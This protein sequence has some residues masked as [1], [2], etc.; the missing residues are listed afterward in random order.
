[1]TAPR[2]LVVDDEPDVEAL[3]TQ[4]FRRKVRSGEI[5]FVFAQDGVQALEVL[6]QTPDFAAETMRT[7]LDGE[8]AGAY[9]YYEVLFGGHNPYMEAIE[10]NLDYLR[11]VLQKKRWSMLRRVPPC[12][13]W[14]KNALQNMRSLVIEYLK[15]A[16]VAA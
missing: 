4:K 14:E 5:E 2:I 9:R 12:F 6:R 11:S 3:I 15:A 1:M 7:R 13:T 8:F 16:V 10:G